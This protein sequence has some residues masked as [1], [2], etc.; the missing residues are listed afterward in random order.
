MLFLNSLYYGKCS[1]INI[2]INFR[3]VTI[4]NSKLVR[5]YLIDL[6]SRLKFEVQKADPS[7]SLSQDKWDRPNG[8]GG[9]SCVFNGKQMEK[10]GVNFSDVKGDCLPPT[11]SKNRPHLI[12]VPFRAMGVSVVFH[13]NNPFV[14][15]AHANVRYFSAENQNNQI[16]W[17]FGGG[18]DLTPYYGFEEDCILWHKKAKQACDVIGQSYYKKFKKACDEYFYLPHR[19]EPRGIGGVFFDDFNQLAFTDCFSFMK[20]IGDTFLNAYFPIFN[21]RK[22][23]P[24]E[25]A[26]KDFQRYRRGRYV[27]FN[28][29]HDRGTLFGLQS[30]GRTESILMSLPPEVNWCYNWSPE[31]GTREADLYDNFLK[32][33]DWI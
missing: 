7:V 22:N 23:I 14:P 24:F 25:N 16:E 18:F 32:V 28:L 21:K 1:V 15:S 19:D 13:P 30:K 27:E 33:K 6:Q 11:A 26:Q 31:Q 20:K 4:K 3:R 8:G 29:I 2:P 5:D 9:E 17:W 10:G 12:G